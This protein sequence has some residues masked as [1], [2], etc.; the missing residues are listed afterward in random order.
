[1]SR[2]LFVLGVFLLLWCASHSISKPFQ[3]SESQPLPDAD[4]Q[5]LLTQ[6]RVPGVSIAVIKDFK[7]AWAKGY[8]I[9][10]VKTGAKVTTDTMFQAASISKTIAAMASLKA[11][12]DGKFTLDQ[13]VNTILKSWK[14]PES[15]FTRE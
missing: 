9:A 10:D 7:I 4:V 8:G 11:I 2:W 5:Q 12:Q 1:M 13:D 15:S 14:V 3:S 6:Y